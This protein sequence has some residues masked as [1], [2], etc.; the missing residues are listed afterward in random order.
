MTTFSYIYI[1]VHGTVLGGLEPH[2]AKEILKESFH[3][4]KGI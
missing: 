1:H 3:S 2:Y 4:E